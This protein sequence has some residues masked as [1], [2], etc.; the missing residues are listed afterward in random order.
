MTGALALKLPRISAAV[1]AALYLVGTAGHLLASTRPIM[2]AV[3]WYVLLL[4]AVLVL[5][6]LAWQGSARMAL[7]CAAAYAAGFLLEVTGVKTGLVFGAY[8]YGSVLGPA[9]LGVPLLIG[10]N[11][12]LV[13]LGCVALTRRL[14]SAPLPAALLAGILTVL[15]DWFMEPVAVRLGYW[16]WAGG[17]IPARNY[18]A[19]FLIS[20]TLAFPA[21]AFFGPALRDHPSARLASV[22][23]AIQL[24]FFAVLRF[25]LP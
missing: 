14:V 12:A 7:W 4:N 16:T 18:A 21:A 24:G 1:I 15:F 11:W 17:V 6:P 13:I 10:L 22:S 23:T 2:A 5:L 20:A 9:V 8:S 3:T 25:T 19:W